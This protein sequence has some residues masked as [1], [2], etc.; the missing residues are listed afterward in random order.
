MK[1]I[2]CVRSREISIQL[3]LVSRSHAYSPGD[4]IR[5]AS[6]HATDYRPVCKHHGP[7]HLPDLQYKPL[8]SRGTSGTDEC[9]D[10]SS[11]NEPWC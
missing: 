8:A 11:N 2:W 1:Y 4:G 5:V 7:L 3:L 6:K 9:A 10:Y